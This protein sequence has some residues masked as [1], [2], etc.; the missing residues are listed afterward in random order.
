MASSPAAAATAAPDGATA[1]SRPLLLVVAVVLLNDEGQV[2]LAQRPPGKALAGLWEYPGGKVDPGETP[3]A[4]LVRELREELAIQVAS[5]SLRPL[6]F[7]SHPYDAFHLLMPTYV[8]SEWEGQP[9]GAE[10][11]ALA[12]VGARE[13]EGGAYPMP[14]ADLPMLAPVLAAMRQHR[15]A[16]QNAA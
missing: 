16:R 9:L 8:A 15:E 7:A 6:T 4:A 3:E 1:K 2:L 11:Q 14:P 13:L 5:A 12:W 10:G